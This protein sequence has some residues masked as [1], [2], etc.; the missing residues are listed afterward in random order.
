MSERGSQRDFLVCSGGRVGGGQGWGA[1]LPW[2]SGS[3]GPW[4]S[5]GAG[6]WGYTT[7][8]EDTRALGRLP[9]EGARGTTVSYLGQPVPP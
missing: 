5:G 8:G 2:G 6:P 9:S 7:V 4:G 3:A 1:V